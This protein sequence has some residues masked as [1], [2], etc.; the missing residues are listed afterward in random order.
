MSLGSIGEMKGAIFGQG[1]N[2]PG[3][4]PSGGESYE[5]PT[6]KSLKNIPPPDL[7]G[8][9]KKQEDEKGFIKHD[10]LQEEYYG[11]EEPPKKKKSWK[12]Y[13]EP[14]CPCC[15]NM[16]KRYLIAILSFFGFLVSFGIRCNL[17]V[18]IVQMVS[19]VTAE[20][21]EF[22]WS[23]ET[24]GVIDSSFF[25]GYLITQIP[26]G[27]LAAKYPANRVF[28]TAIAVSSLLNL[29]I[30]G[31][32]T[33]H[34]A[35]VIFVRILQGLVEGVTY[36]AC[37]GI[38]RHWAPPL[39]RSRLATLAFCGS[40]AGAVMGMP[41]SGLL[42]DHLGWQACF[43]FYGA[44]G[45]IWYIFWMWQSFEKPSKHPTITQEELI[46]IEH[47]LG[48]SVG[49]STLTL[50]STPWKAILT[51]MPVYAII[52][53]NFARSWSFYLLLI[54]QPMYFKEV[55]HFNV[56]K[57]G[58]LGALP[59][60]LMTI[61][62]PIG[63]QLADHLRRRE[64]L[65][66][67]SVR[68]IFNCGGFGLEAV[69]LLVV[70]YTRNTTLALI[71][72]IIAVGFSGFA[73]S[74]FNVNHLDIAPRYASILMGMSNGFG[75]LSGMICPIVVET[76]TKHS[77]AAEWEKVFLIAS[78]IHFAGVTFYAIFAS[79][80]LQSWAEPPVKD[81]GAS[82]NPLENAFKDE[83]QSKNG[84]VTGPI[85]IAGVKQPSYG[86][87]VDSQ[88]PMFDMKK[89]P[90]QAPPTDRYMHGSIEDREY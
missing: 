32:S 15:P 51:S 90:V 71:S 14:N 68:K 2:G 28:G 80:E 50:K 48:D 24:I 81:E 20:G 49:Q 8:K 25:W 4:L 11:G 34:P 65:T 82:W 61:V 56:D 60:L 33:V 84:D 75:T 58:V 74:G 12:Q 62:V 70:G 44:C 78:L 9:L 89:E 73:I 36:P 26:G 31:A 86:A 13:L 79:G 72:L 22:D 42:T 38:W 10:E 29:L 23:P 19:N 66:T 53:A 27:F 41:L 87:T 64:Y 57:S 40:Y 67:T 6:I 88:Q 1:Q 47:S 69:F 35:M 59:H 17:G 77:T 85:A 83:N 63:G 55:F 46:Y 76:L 54:S 39:E 37:H 5:M 7:I 21:P 52:I 30:P 3:K 45:I 43:Y 16:S 18:A